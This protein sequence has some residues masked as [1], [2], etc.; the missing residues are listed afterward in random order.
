MADTA[1]DLEPVEDFRR[2]LREWLPDNM[3]RASA[4]SRLT[5]ARGTMTDEEELE[6]VAY[7]RQLQRKLYDGGFAGIIFPKEYGG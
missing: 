6:D 2:R 3:P 7:N 1:R 4:R 5:M